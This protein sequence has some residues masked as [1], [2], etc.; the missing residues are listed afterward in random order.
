MGITIKTSFNYEYE[1]SIHF[2]FNDIYVFVLFG[3]KKNNSK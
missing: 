1:S 2:T 3:S